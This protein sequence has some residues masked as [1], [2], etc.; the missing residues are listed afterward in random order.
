LAVSAA[1]TET[2]IPMIFVV[3][4]SARSAGRSLEQRVDELA[5][6]WKLTP[7]QAETLALLSS[8]HSNK[9]IATS[10]RVSVRTIEIHVSS[11]LQ[12]AA[13][14][15]RSELLARLWAGPRRT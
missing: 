15:S 13:C 2:G 12:K 8:G 11:V 5:A 10:L 7:R 3:A 4:A 14:T 9:E 6:V 1:A